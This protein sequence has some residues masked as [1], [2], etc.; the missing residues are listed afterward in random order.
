MERSGELGL[1]S[2]LAVSREFQAAYR[3]INDLV[4]VRLSSGKLA[5]LLLSWVGLRH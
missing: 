5:R 1:R 2:A 4:L 3:D